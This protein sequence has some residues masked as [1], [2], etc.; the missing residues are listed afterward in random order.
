MG[1]D[2]DCGRLH[3]CVQIPYFEIPTDSVEPN[4]HC[5][6]TEVNNAVGD[7][8]PSCGPGLACALETIGRNNGPFYKLEKRLANLQTFPLDP[9]I[10]VTRL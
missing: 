9:Q 6:I 3:T 7:P 8:P 2:R 1:Y 4:T 10:L 5:T